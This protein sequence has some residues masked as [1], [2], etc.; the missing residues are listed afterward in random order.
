M[1]TVKNFI[2]FKILPINTEKSHK[3]K[4]GGRYTFKVP[5]SYNKKE[6]VLELQNLFGVK[7]YSIKTLNVR[8]KKTNF[9]RISG[10]R[11]KYKKV[12]VKFFGNEEI[13]FDKL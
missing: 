10:Q 9:K 2:G 6:I 8:G 7:V 12:Y 11:S 1:N 5:F 4:N 13:N 3:V